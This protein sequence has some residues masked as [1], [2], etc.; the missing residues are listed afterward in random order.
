MDTRKQ[1]LLS[2]T[3]SI[4]KLYLQ[5]PAKG[6]LRGGICESMQEECEF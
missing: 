5:S 6:S 1:I 2:S 4:D 3:H